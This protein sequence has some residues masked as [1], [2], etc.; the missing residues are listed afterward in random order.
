MTQYI[1]YS[2]LSRA[3]RAEHDEVSFNL[4]A[5]T[6]EL[7]ADGK[8]IPVPVVPIKLTGTE[9]LRFMQPYAT[10]RFMDQA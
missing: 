1:T 9:K 3:R 7:D 4:I 6:P 8:P 10:V 5:L 2:D